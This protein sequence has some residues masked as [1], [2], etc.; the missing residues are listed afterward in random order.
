MSAKM[1]PVGEGLKVDG[2]GVYFLY[3][4]K[5]EEI[6]TLKAEL[7]AL[8]SSQMTEAK[9]REVLGIAIVNEN[10]SLRADQPFVTYYTNQTDPPKSLLDGFFTSLQ[11]RAIA[12]WMDNMGGE[13]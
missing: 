12:W 9:A 5:L 11:L 8:R 6:K 2:N 13:R 4:Q 10:N 1:Y 7:T 3:Q